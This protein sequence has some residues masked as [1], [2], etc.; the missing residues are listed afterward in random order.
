MHKSPSVHMSNGSACHSNSTA[1]AL[2]VL[3][4][5]QQCPML[6]ATVAENLASKCFIMQRNAHATAI[7]HFD[8]C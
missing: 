1:I 7:I 2:Y 4:Q 6:Q 3:E 8:N 5:Y